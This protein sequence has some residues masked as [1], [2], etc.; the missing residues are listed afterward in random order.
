[1]QRKIRLLDPET[2]NQIA[3]GEV[4]LN[5]ASVVKELVDNSIDAGASKIVVEI[6]GG[7]REL[8]RVRDNGCG[9]SSEDAPLAFAL[10]ATSKISAIGD[11]ESIST[12]G[13]RGEALASVAAVARVKLKTRQAEGQGTF[14]SIEGGKVLSQTQVPCDPGTTIEVEDLFYNI[15]ARRKFLKSPKQ[16]NQEVFKCLSELALAYPEIDFQLIV[17]SVKSIDVWKEGGKD[18][19]ADM[20]KRAKELFGFQEKEWF[21][22]S[23]E[24]QGVKITGLLSNASHHR[25]NRT[26]QYLFLN[27]RPIQAWQIAQAITQ[28]YGTALP[29]GRHPLFMLHVGLDGEAFDINVHPQ[30]R[31]VRFRH[32]GELRD[33]VRHAVSRALLDTYQPS[34]I[35]YTLPT[36][37]TPSEPIDFCVRET[38]VQPQLFSEPELP[39]ILAALPGYVLLE[40]EP[41]KG[42]C[43]LDQKGAEAR[44][45]FERSTK[46]GAGSSQP[47]LAPLSLKLDPQEKALL[48]DKREDLATQGFHVKEGPDGSYLLESVPTKALE[49]YEELFFA[50]LHGEP[51]GSERLRVQK[52]RLPHTEAYLLLRELV[53]CREPDRSPKGKALY[54]WLSFQELQK[55]F[56]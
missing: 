41:E 9:M 4:I 33:L 15:P 25:P 2:I 48:E 51:Q 29:Q 47:L 10:H 44:I 37:F 14:L 3:A 28:G 46:N 32:E 7:G 52:R 54:A 27:K 43:I 21:T 49:D 55:L 18:Q 50:Y 53:K 23:F 34:S 38:M 31:E 20:K 5:P 1:M 30:K 56:K 17:D 12:L 45:L 39:H 8:I 11:I 24:E 16:E 35:S 36:A 13:F 22:I 6:K 26:G 40:K 19:F 42:L